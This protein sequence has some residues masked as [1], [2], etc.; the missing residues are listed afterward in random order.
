MNKII[1]K[2]TIHYLT[3]TDDN[4]A[5]YNFNDS[6]FV[7]EDS[8]EVRSSIMDNMADNGGVDTAQGGSPARQITVE[9]MIYSE[10]EADFEVSMRALQL[11]IKKGGLLSINADVVTRNI[12]VNFVKHSPEW[13]RYQVC[14]N[15]SITFECEF[16]YWEDTAYTDDTNI[17]TGD[18][19]FTTDASGSDDI[20]MPVITF[21]ADQGVDVPGIKLTNTDDGGMYFEFNCP[22][23]LA[24][25]I[26]VIDNSDGSCLLNGNDAREF[27]IGGSAFLRLQSMINNFNYEGAACTVVISFKRC[28]V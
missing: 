7:Q 28:Y 17:M 15:V 9:G 11:A 1:T 5:A 2:S 19:A 4:G 12:Y 14:K 23:F 16:P 24:G 6:F 27:I 26:L 13:K 20:M 25:D 10:T 18:G 8:L 3:L 21:N 22:Q